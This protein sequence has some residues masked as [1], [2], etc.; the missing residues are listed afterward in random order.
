MGVKSMGEDKPWS[1]PFIKLY[2]RGTNKG[3]GEDVDLNVK[4]PKFQGDKLIQDQVLDILEKVVQFAAPDPESLKKKADDDFD[5][6]PEED[7]DEDEGEKKDE[8]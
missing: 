4:E 6:E 2:K 7:E 3:G 5:F 8:L 1:F